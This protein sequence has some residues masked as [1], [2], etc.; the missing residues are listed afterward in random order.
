MILIWTLS[1]LTVVG[2]TVGGFS[3]VD[4]VDLAFDRERRVRFGRAA[5]DTRPARY[6]I[7]SPGANLARN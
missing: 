4:I 6:L 7:R 5:G 2:A 3:V 1:L